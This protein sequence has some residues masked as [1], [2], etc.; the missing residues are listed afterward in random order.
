MS[1]RMPVR[2]LYNVDHTDNGSLWKTKPISVKQ[3]TVIKWT[4]RTD[5]L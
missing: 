1:V 3:C 5:E 4:C 2:E